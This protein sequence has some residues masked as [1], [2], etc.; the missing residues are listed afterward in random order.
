MTTAETLES[1]GPVEPNIPLDA[2]SSEL[3][4]S[5]QPSLKRYVARHRD[6]ASTGAA[7]A[8]FVA[9]LIYGAGHLRRASCS[10]ARS[11]TC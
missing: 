8:I 5:N 10:R 7:L 2:E 11:R 9:M 1:V 6:A 4:T 3:H